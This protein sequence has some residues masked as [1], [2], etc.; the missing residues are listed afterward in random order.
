MDVC[1]FVRR[2]ACQPTP[3]SLKI[4]LCSGYLLDSL[5]VLP[6]YAGKLSFH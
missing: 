1:V 5:S 3:A 4:V 2:K 6:L